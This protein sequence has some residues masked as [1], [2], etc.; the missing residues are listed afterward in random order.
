ME[1]YVQ[2]SEVQEQIASVKE[3]VESAGMQIELKGEGDK[4]IYVYTI[5]SAYVTDTTADQLESGIQ[6]QSSTFEELAAALKKAGFTEIKT[7]TNTNK[8]WICIV[9][10]K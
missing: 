10:T 2:S 4:L 9:A 8:H 5:D 3:Q 1:D 7:Y 6:A